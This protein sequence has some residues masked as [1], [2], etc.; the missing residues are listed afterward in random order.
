MSTN[1]S[2]LMLFLQYSVLF[3]AICHTR[4]LLRV[5]TVNILTGL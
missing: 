5:F 2:W 3:D 1:P 4:A